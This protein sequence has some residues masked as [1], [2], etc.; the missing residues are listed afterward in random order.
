MTSFSLDPVQTLRKELMN[1]KIYSSIKTV[2]DLSIFMQHHV[3]SVWD[4]MSL[5]KYLQNHIAPSNTSWSDHQDPSVKRFINELV[6]EEESDHGIALED[7]TQTFTSHFNLYL[8]A[9]EEIEADS[10]KDVQEFTKYIQNS[11]FSIASL[12]AKIPKP[13]KEFMEETYSFIQTDKPHVVAAAFTF[14][15]EHIIPEMF[16]SLLDKLDIPKEQ[17]KVFRYYL[18]RHIDLDKNSH[19]PMALKMLEILCDNDIEKITQAQEAAVSA[20]KAR[21]KFWDNVLEVIEGKD[22]KTKLF[23]KFFKKK[24]LKSA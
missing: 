20:I 13:A 7:G 16:Q 18:E 15:R 3:Y 2:E 6:L 12:F 19:G 9:M 5:L 23:Q 10:S 8:Q 24:E 14:G 21:I 11:S 4:F 1:H 22:S 17:T